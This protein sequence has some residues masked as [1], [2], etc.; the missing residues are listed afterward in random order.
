MFTI[1]LRPFSQNTHARLR[2]RRRALRNQCR[3][4]AHIQP[5]RSGRVNVVRQHVAIVAKMRPIREPILL[6]NRR[7]RPHLRT[8]APIAFARLTR[9]HPRERLQRLLTWLTLPTGFLDRLIQ[10]V[11]HRGSDRLLRLSTQLLLQPRQIMRGADLVT[12]LIHRHKCRRHVRRQ[13]QIVPQIPANIDALHLVRRAHKRVKEVR[14]V[15]TFS[16]SRDFRS[17]DFRGRS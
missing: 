12:L 15:L 13:V 9:I 5:V 14:Q 16:R 2:V 3:I 11:A 10:R 17:L 6:R 4:R 7:N 8:L 1:R